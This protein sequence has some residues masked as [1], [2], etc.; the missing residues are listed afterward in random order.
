LPPVN[1]TTIEQSLS[2]SPLLKA[3]LIGSP[4]QHDVVAV[5]RETLDNISSKA[6]AS[7]NHHADR[8]HLSNVPFVPEAGHCPCC[9]TILT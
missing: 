6:R 1:S 7:A 2:P 5:T 3:N 8:F 9:Q 4:A